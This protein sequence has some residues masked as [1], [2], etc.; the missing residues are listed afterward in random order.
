[1]NINSFG[2]NRE[3]LVVISL[4]RENIK[5]GMIYDEVKIIIGSGGKK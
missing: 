5:V 3:V 1:M 4:N 2:I